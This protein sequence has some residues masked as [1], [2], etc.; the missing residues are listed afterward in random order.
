MSRFQYTNRN[1]ELLEPYEWK[2]SR[3]VLRGESSCKGADLPDRPSDLQQRDGRA[4]RKGN[5]IAKLYADSKVD[6]IIYA[7]E[8]SLDSYKFNLLQNKQTFINQLKTNTLG[9]RRIDE[10]NIDES[11]GM[12]FSEYVAILSGNTDLLEKAKLEKQ[13]N[14]LESEK[15]AFGKSKS[16]AIVK[17]NDATRSIDG[18]NELIVRMQKDRNSFI[19]QVK[20]DKDGNKLNPIK[21]DNFDSTD[22][23]SI[24]EKLNKLADS[25]RTN[26]EYFRIG[27][28]YG[29]KL[30]VKTEESLKE[31]SLFR[32]NRFFIEGEGGIK[33]NYNNGHIA[34]DPLLVSRNF[35]NALEKIPALI[36]KYEKENEQLSRDLPILKEVMDATF[37]KEP[38]LKEL[39]IRLDSLSR[40]I[41]LSLENNRNAEVQS[42]STESS[43]QKLEKKVKSNESYDNKI[44]PDNSYSRTRQTISIR[45]I[46]DT[47]GG[48][49]ITARADKRDEQ[50]QEN[51]VTASV[52]QVKGV[53][54]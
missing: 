5:E 34:S 1:L 54:L 43:N 37:R 45:E 30:L 41:N 21:L 40:Q 27:E 39:K 22:L 10:G 32:D 14:T 3:T 44:P 6:V 12:N 9:S 4:I 42:I 53:K 51:S 16:S 31:G 46:V 48:R 19:S 52:R 38:E 13:I 33:Y 25:S 50:L 47:M 8:K 20:T 26:G 11:S 23:K 18:N 24:G 2:R 17:Y 15:K 49:L 7:V 29:F 28:L 35:L 36:E